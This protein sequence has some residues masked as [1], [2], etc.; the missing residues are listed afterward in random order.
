MARNLEAEEAG[1]LGLVQTIA[2]P[3]V[4]GRIDHMEVDVRGQR[5][6]IAALGNNTVEVLD[7][8]GGK[9]IRTITGLHEPQAISFVPELNKIFVANAKSGAVDIFDGGSFQL[10]KS[11]KLGDDADNIRYDASAHR[12]YIGYGSGGLG[13]VDPTNGEKIGD[14]KLDSHPESFQL[15]KS[16]PRIFV[17]LPAVGKIAV[18]NRETHVTLAD[19]PTTG[20]TANFPMALDEIRHRLFVGFRKPAKLFVYDTESGKEVAVL[21]SPGDADDT[22]YDALRKRIYISGG[23]GSIGIV[24]QQDA[25]H[26]KTITKI[27]TASG[28][29]TSFWSPD[30]NR[31]YLAVPHRG[32]QGAKIRAYEA[33]R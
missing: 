29:R 12:L 18:V 5:L 25:D 10:I 13:I 27:A 15:E 33:Q 14:V 9:R 3:N 21:D 8:R 30:T 16:G 31:L 22:F 28:A 19:W 4:E 20:V 26:Y 2:L 24:Q 7:L 32:T 17:N 1:P 6:F 11:V 23:E